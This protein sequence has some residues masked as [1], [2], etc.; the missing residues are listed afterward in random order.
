MT[1]TKSGSRSQTL[2]ARKARKVS[3][4]ALEKPA[5]YQDSHRG[6]EFREGIQ[7]LNSQKVPPLISSPACL[8]KT[9]LFTIQ[10]FVEPAP[11]RPSLDHLILKDLQ[12]V[13]TCTM[14]VPSLYLSQSIIIYLDCT[15]HENLDC[16]VHLFPSAPDQALHRC[17]Q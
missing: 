8:F 2:T 13:V 6:K 1:L 14:F 10:V 17:S 3:R 15:F 7:M 5:P 16:S 12:S 9:G 11:Q 4:W